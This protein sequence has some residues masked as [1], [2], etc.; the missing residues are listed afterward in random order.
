MYEID[1]TRKA[2]KQLMKLDS[3][4]DR[5]AVY[6]AVDGLTAWPD[7]RN[8]KALSGHEYS[9]RLR[10]GRFRVLFDV[11]EAVKVIAIQEV[12]KRDERTY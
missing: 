5:D 9:Y 11:H 2:L 6:G 12:R 1:W 4:Q 7:C 3:R 10:V 8:I